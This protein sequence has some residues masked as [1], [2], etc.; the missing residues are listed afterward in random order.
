M[1]ITSDITREKNQEQLRLVSEEVRAWCKK[2]TPDT[3]KNMRSTV[4]LILT[5]YITVPFCWNQL[6]YV[7][8]DL[9]SWYY[10]IFNHV[11]VLPAHRHF[12]RTT[13]QW[14]QQIK[15]HTQQQLL[16]HIEY[17]DALLQIFSIPT[18]KFCLLM[19]P[20]NAPYCSKQYCYQPPTPGTNINIANKPLFHGQWAVLQLEFCTDESSVGHA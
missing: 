12:V 10:N 5:I 16:G 11:T 1:H 19:A 20:H 18:L 7:L 14:V 17:T 9:Y 2:E 3:E 8:R 4:A 6:F 13:G 15:Q